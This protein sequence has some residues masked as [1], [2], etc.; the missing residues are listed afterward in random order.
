MKTN[1]CSR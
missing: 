1:R